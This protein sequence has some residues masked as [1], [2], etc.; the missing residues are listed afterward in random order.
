MLSFDNADDRARPAMAIRIMAG[1]VKPG[2]GLLPFMVDHQQPQ[3]EVDV[4]A[5]GPGS[6]PRLL[7]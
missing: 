2:A 1:T 3:H 6:G 4:I 7:R 5:D